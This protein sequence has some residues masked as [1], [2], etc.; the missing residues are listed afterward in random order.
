[1]GWVRYLD[2]LGQ[3]VE[4]TNRA[5]FMDPGCLCRIDPEYSK[6]METWRIERV[7][8]IHSPQIGPLSPESEGR[9]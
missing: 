3:F 6:S 1:M 7:C 9:E 2:R 4:T 5:Q 8:P